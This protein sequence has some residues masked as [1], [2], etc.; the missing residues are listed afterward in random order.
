MESD[1][2]D[3][4]LSQWNRERPD[5]DVS[6]MAV[7]GRLTRLSKVIQ[8][9]L[10]TVFAEHD[11]EFWEFDVLATLMRNGSDQQLTPGQLLK[12]MMLTSGAMTNRIDR[13]EKRGYV[14]RVR[15]RQVLVTLTAKGLA[16]A[17]GALVDHAA[18]ELSLI[19]SLDDTQ[20]AQLI[21]LLTILQHAIMS[22]TDLGPADP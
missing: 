18:N 17:E 5:V 9:R 4:I 16:K 2:V 11:L 22:E 13:L 6:G 19:Q 8:N 14:D 12:S 21:E 10:N 1:H 15:G 20:R 7:I 3:E